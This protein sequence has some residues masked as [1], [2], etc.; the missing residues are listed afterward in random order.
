VPVDC[1]VLQVRDDGVGFDQAAARQP[2]SLG[3][4]GLRERAQLLEGQ[5]RID[6]VPGA[7]TTVEARLPLPIE[8]APAPGVRP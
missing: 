3:L 5:V 2:Q 7:G 8:P 1:I 6:S 4:I